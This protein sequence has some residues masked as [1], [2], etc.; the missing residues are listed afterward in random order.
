M[1]TT[2]LVVAL[3]LIALG[4]V[5]LAF[6]SITFFTHDRVVDAGPF[7]VDVARP[8]TIFLNPIVGIVAMVVG[9]AL[10]LASQRPGRV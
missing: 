4:V 10:L 5:G 3:L 6:Q 9:A 7:T 2:L 8:H 1:R